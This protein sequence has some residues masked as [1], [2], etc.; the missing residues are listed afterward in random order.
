MV[1]F[2]KAPNG[3]YYLH[4]NRRKGIKVSRNWWLIKYAQAYGSMGVL[5]L[6]CISPSVPKELVGKRVRIKLEVIK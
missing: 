3:E 4:R 1:R 5:N 6:V 2:V